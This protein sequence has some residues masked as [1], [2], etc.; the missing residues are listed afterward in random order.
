MHV[1]FLY[2]QCSVMLKCYL[3]MFKKMGYLVYEARE[4]VYKL[5]YFVTH[6]CCF[7][8]T[9]PYSVKI[10]CYYVRKALVYTTYYHVKHVCC[11]VQTVSY[12]VKRL[13][14][15]VKNFGYLV[16][17]I[18]EL[19]YTTFYYSNAVLILS[20]QCLIMVDIY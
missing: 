7:I 11:L 10:L 16:Y 20:T 2:T 1:L 3:I 14:Y 5:C 13:S 4:F 8:H 12:Y 15:C 17:E 9:L 6:M 18:C 19:V